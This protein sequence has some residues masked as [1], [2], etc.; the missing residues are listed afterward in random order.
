[1]RGLPFGRR[2]RNL[3]GIDDGAGD[4]V[5][6]RE[7]VPD[8]AVVALGP[9]A[10]PIVHGHE[11]DGDPDAIAGSPHGAVEQ[12]AHL[13]R[14]SDLGG[15]RLGEPVAERGRTRGD[16]EALHAPEGDQNLFGDALAEITLVARLAHVGERKHGDRPAVRADRRLEIGAKTLEPVLQLGRGLPAPRG[17]FLE[18]LVD[19]RSEL[20]GQARV[21][22][23]DGN[24]RV[25]QDGR[26]HRDEIGAFEG[27]LARRH[28]VEQHPYAED[29]GPAV[30]GL[31]L[32]LLGRHVVRRADQAMAQRVEMRANL[33][34]IVARLRRGERGQAEIEQFGAAPGEHHVRRRQVPVHHAVG[35]SL[36]EG[37]SHLD[38]DVERLFERQRALHEPLGERL[39]LEV[40]HHEEVDGTRR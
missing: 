21:E 22:P 24:L 28:L 25:A 36:V 32:R 8:V 2:Q 12:G 1:M 18:A 16:A 19:D 5:L 17:L 10:E 7:D 6:E 3:E 39:A 20:D 4:F 34:G 31:P 26:K 29:V 38:G 35:M 23:R 14:A 9:Q 13:E 27:P 30:G 11:R 37:V 33:A 15:I 40:L